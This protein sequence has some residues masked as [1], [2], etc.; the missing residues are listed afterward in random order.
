M[1]TTIVPAQVT[2][3]EDKIAG[4]LSLSQLILLAAPVF[5][6][7]ALYIIFPP[8]LRLSP[9]KLGLSILLFVVFAVMSIRVKGKILLVWTVIV[10]RYGLR[11]RYYVFN[12]NDAYLRDIPDGKVTQTIEPTAFESEAN[13]APLLP[14]MTTSQLARLEAILANPAAKLHFKAHKKGGLRVHITEVKQE[15]L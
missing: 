1:K 5:L 7:S 12:K 2:T 10:L 3:V 14:T 4:S 15:S 9:L 13:E 8:I 11:P 6:G